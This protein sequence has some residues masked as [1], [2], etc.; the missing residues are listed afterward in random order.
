[1]RNSRNAVR[2]THGSRA[3]GIRL[4]R[5]LDDE[6]TVARDLNDGLRRPELV[7][8][9]A[10][11]TFGATDRV[12]AVGDLATRL[13]DLEREMNAAAEVESHLDGNSADGGVAHLT[14]S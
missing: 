1:M 2:S 10:D 13:V 8:A 7:H 6:A 4:A 5:Q 12:G 3:C 11:D 9:C 14:G